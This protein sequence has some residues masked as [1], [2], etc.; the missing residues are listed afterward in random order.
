[1]SNHAQC[2]QSECRVSFAHMRYLHLPK[3]KPACVSKAQEKGCE[4]RAAAHSSTALSRPMTSF[5]AQPYIMIC[6]GDKEGGIAQHRKWSA[7]AS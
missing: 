6:N 7:K 1:M 5:C 3:K 2:C 4:D